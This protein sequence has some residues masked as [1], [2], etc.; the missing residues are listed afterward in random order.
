[1][2]WLTG[3]LGSPRSKTSALA[4]HPGNIRGAEFITLPS[5]AGMSVHPEAALAVSMVFACVRALSESVAQLPWHVYERLA[6]GRKRIALDHP[7]QPALRRPN[8]WQTP[9]EFKEFVMTC[10]GLRGNSYA[11]LLPGVNGSATELLPLHPDR[12]EPVR[13]ANGRLAYIVRNSEGRTV[14]LTQDEVWHTRWFS[15]DGVIGRTP[16]EYAASAARLAKSAETFGTAFFDNGARPG[17]VLSTDQNV[18]LPVMIET[19]KQWEEKHKGAAKAHGTAVLTHNLKPIELGLSQADSQFLE[20]RRF[21]NEDIARIFRMPPHLVGD[22]SRATNNNITEQGRE[23]LMYT[24]M[25]WLI[26]IEESMNRDLVVEDQFYVKFNP[27]GYLRADEKTRMECHQ[28]AIFSSVRTPN[29]CRELEDEPP[30]PGGDVLLAQSA[31]VPLDRLLADAPKPSQAAQQ[32]VVTEYGVML[33]ALQSRCDRLSH[34]IEAKHGSD[35]EATKRLAEIEATLSA[36]RDAADKLREDVS[37]SRIDADEMRRQLTESNSRRR[38]LESRLDA[39]SGDLTAATSRTSAVVEQSKRI[40]LDALSA[41]FKIE[42]DAAITAT[43]KENFLAAIEDLHNKQRDRMTRALAPLAALASVATGRPIDVA[44]AIR[45]H[46]DWSHAEL[47]NAA[48]VQPHELA[49][50]VEK[51]IAGWADRPVA[52]IEHLFQGV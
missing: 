13:I 2:S 6:D 25:P 17:V 22:L 44:P 32:S 36:E 28:V 5:G 48:S 26:R 27:A 11:Q 9:F 45:D 21:Q 23:F 41:V 46:V 10:L 24:L 34:T 3:L 47:L 42:C 49:A 35:A 16:I 43:R 15:L 51:T 20:T 14:R 33:A 8:S 40:M 38:E 50:S 52:F 29:E 12:V 37:A 39:L 18:P 7:L 1:M 4:E 19:K 30:L 31:M